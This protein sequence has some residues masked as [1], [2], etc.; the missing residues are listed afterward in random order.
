MKPNRIL[1]NAVGNPVFDVPLDHPVLKKL[2]LGAYVTRKHWIP[3]SIPGPMAN[4]VHRCLPNWIPGQSEEHALLYNRP[5]SEIRN[6]DY[7][8]L[9]ANSACFTADTL[10]DQ[11]CDCNLQ[12]LAALDLIEASTEPGLV[13][14]HCNHEGRGNGLRDKLATYDG[15]MFPTPEMRDFTH[16]VFIL[17]SLGIKR[18]KLMTNN[19]HKSALLQEFGIEILEEIPLVCDPTRFVDLFDEKATLFGHRLPRKERQS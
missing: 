4:C 19:P 13:I 1:P 14:Y 9:R 17:K 18:V 3:S 7:I 12:F 16:T 5:I 6:A 8:L 11:R 10:G 2:L 15:V